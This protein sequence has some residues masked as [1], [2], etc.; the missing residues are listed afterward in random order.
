M[1][2]CCL[3]GYVQRLDAFA[4]PICTSHSAWWISRITNF[5]V[6]V[7]TYSYVLMH[8]SSWVITELRHGFSEF[9]EVNVT[10]VNIAQ[11]GL[12]YKSVR[13]SIVIVVD[14]TVRLECS[15]SSFGSL[16]RYSQLSACGSLSPLKIWTHPQSG[17]PGKTW[18][19]ESVWSRVTTS[20]SR[21]YRS[22]C[23]SFPYD[24]PWQ[25]Y[26]PASFLRMVLKYGRTFLF[27]WIF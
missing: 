11:P 14:A 2:R 6:N 25:V 20:K 24:R 23:Q 3:F 18:P 27:G 12:I 9:G 8:V 13:A 22:Y 5:H 15:M 19:T 17:H 21:R 1:I 16:Q 4:V 7:S 10:Q 26:L